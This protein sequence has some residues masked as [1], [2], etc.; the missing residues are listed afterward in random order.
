MNGAKFHVYFYYD[1]T[2]RAYVNLPKHIRN[3]PKSTFPWKY[4]LNDELYLSTNVQSR[5]IWDV[6]SICYLLAAR[7]GIARLQIFALLGGVLKITNKIKKNY[8][9]WCSRS[10]IMRRLKPLLDFARVY[11]YISFA[12]CL[13]LYDKYE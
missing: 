4:L 13:W 11:K 7:H 8:T 10:E 1:T 12:Y 6:F 9:F 2:L 5:G 3:P